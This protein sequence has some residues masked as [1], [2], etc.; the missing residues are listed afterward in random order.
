MCPPPCPCTN[1]F[2]CFLYCKV[3]LCQEQNDWEVV[4]AAVSA[5]SVAAYREANADRMGK[6]A[7]NL[8]PILVGLLAH[9]DAEIQAHTATAL[10]NLAH[11]SPAYQSDA[12]A[13]GA[14]EALID[15]CR[16]RAG[17]GEGRNI[18]SMATV[19]CT[20]QSED[21]GEMGVIE[22]VATSSVRSDS[23]STPKKAKNTDEESGTGERWARKTGDK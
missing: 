22:V 2:A 8:I 12:G 10:A 5:L 13:A 18:H 15:V 21:H 7:P 1:V 4:R 14:I 11:G 6:A 17:A 23:E 19:E 16:G 9:P 20:R 3:R